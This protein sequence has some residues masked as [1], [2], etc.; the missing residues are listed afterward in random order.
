MT[1]QRTDVASPNSS[2]EHYVAVLSKVVRL[3]DDGVGFA[4][5]PLE[6]HSSGQAALKSNL[7]GTKALANFLEQLK[8]DQ[9]HLIIGHRIE[10][11][12]IKNIVEVEV[13]NPWRELY[14]N[15]EG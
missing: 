9:G 1:L 13:S 4:F 8:Q 7:V 5:V 12:I 6:T 15:S 14:E 11:L 10:T 2:G 3:G